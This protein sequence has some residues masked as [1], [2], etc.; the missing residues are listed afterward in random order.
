V[1][2]CRWPHYITYIA[3]CVQECNPVE[4]YGRAEP[5]RPFLRMDSPERAHAAHTISQT[6]NSLFKG[7]YSRTAG[8]PELY[9]QV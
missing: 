9:N 5:K 6:A 3:G 8:S 7:A 2:G 1:V 4:V